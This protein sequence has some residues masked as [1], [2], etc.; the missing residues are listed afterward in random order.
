MVFLYNLCVEKDS[1]FQNIK[2]ICEFQDR[3]VND[4]RYPHKYEINENDVN[5]SINSVEKVK[6]LKPFINIRNEINN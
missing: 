2:T 4:I 5:F 1:E 3:F 6:S